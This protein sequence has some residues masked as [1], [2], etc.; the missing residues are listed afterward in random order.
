[1][2]EDPSR[3]ALDRLRAV[4][5]TDQGDFAF[6]HRRSRAR[7]MTEYLRR[8]ALWA[9]AFDA[10]GHWPFF[11]IARHIDPVDHTSPEVTAALD[12][13]VSR[14]FG[15]RTLKQA[16]RG[17]VHWPAFRRGTKVDLPGLPDPYEPLLLMFERGG[18]FS[19]EEMIDL[20]G[21]AVPL[22]PMAHYLSLAPAATLT[23][24]ALD[25]LDTE[26][27]ARGV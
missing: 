12:E 6:G 7:L 14:T 21:I 8:S 17:A 25:A 15:R 27:D 22:R 23:P 24:D 1:M 13:F 2:T 5:W 10:R 20:D 19:I 18:G 26:G 3:I 9:D 16:C 4:R 11:D